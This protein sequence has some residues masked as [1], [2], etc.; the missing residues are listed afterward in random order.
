M[1]KGF[2]DCW[3]GCTADWPMCHMFQE[4]KCY[5]QHLREYCSKGWHVRENDRRTI[6]YYNEPPRKK[7]RGDYVASTKTFRT[8]QAQTEK[9]DMRLSRLG[10][11]D[12]EP[13]TQALLEKTYSSR[14]NAVKNSQDSYADQKH[15]LKKL[16][17]AFSNIAKTLHGQAPE[18]SSDDD[19]EQ[20]SE[21]PSET[22]SAADPAR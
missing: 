10:F 20:V 9:Q 11:F 21:K 8:E 22:E 12:G 18:P 2:N 7:R 6:D 15:Q 1:N 4:N 19:E 13:L 17:S 14:K 3:H 5:A 16:K